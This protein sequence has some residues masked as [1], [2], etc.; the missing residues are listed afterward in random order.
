MKK[1]RFLALVLAGVMAVSNT[2]WAGVP[3]QREEIRSKLEALPEKATPSDADR[4]ETATDSNA[5]VNSQTQKEPLKMVR[6]SRIDHPDVEAVDREAIKK[7]IENH[8]F[9]MSMADTWTVMPDPANEIAG[10][11]S[12][13]SVE[14]A[15]NTFNFV[16]YVAGLREVGNNDTLEEHVQTGTTL[17]QRVGEL[18]HDPKKPDGMSDTF[19]KKGEKGTSESN[20]AAGYSTLSHAIIR[21]WMDDGDTKNI[22]RESSG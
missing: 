12:D 22:E 10:K 9:S 15:L 21:G 18:T 6:A 5:V 4:D 7:Y 8:P 13:E 17:L 16:R 19:F 14:N 3:G 20:I 11:L 2:A 1:R